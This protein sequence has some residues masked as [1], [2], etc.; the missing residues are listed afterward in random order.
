M[1]LFILHKHNYYPKA[2][3]LTTDNKP[4]LSVINI[5]VHPKKIKPWTDI[6]GQLYPSVTRPGR[7][8]F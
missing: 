4:D 3:P 1:C 7:I 5:S 2:E 8:K 6:F